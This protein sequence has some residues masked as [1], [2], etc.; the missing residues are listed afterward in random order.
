[1]SE[2]MGM[3]VML[4]NLKAIFSAYTLFLKFRDYESK[5][6]NNC[7]CKSSPWQWCKILAI[8]NSSLQCNNGYVSR[9][10]K[11]RNT[12]QPFAIPNN[13]IKTLKQ[14]K[15]QTGVG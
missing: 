12:R 14:T 10:I 8:Q 1:M 5:L 3:R 11:T 4:K 13:L 6:T 9:S 2:R 7:N 15:N